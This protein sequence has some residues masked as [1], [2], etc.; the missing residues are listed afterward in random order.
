M[1]N[2]RPSSNS[3]ASKQSSSTSLLF[4]QPFNSPDSQDLGAGCS[5]W[6]ALGRTILVPSRTFCR[7]PDSDSSGSQQRPT[8]LPILPRTVPAISITT[9]DT[10]SDLFNLSQHFDPAFIRARDKQLLYNSWPRGSL[11]SS[12]FPATVFQLSKY[13]SGFSLT[14]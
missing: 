7:T 6:L 4:T 5:R 9:S 12:D 3:T 13:L 2:K 1:S 11:I 10:R 14:C 8:W